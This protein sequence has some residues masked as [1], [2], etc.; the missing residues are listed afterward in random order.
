VFGYIATRGHAPVVEGEWADYA[1]ANAP[2]ACW[3]NAP[4]SAPRFLRYLRARQFGLIIT[5]MVKGQLLESTNLDDPTRFRSN[6][7][8]TDGLD[9][10]AGQLV[11]QWLVQQNT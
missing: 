3:D 11:R 6:W 8:C 10:G 4:V 7:S 9:Q 1:R 5:Q 2:W